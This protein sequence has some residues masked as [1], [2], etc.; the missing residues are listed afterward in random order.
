[1]LL[2]QIRQETDARAAQ[3]DAGGDADNHAL[4]VTEPAD[5]ADAQRRCRRPVTSRPASRPVGCCWWTSRS[6]SRRTTWWRSRRRALRNRRVGHA[7]TLDPFASGLLVLLVGRETRL[8][9]YV[10]GDPKVYEATVRFGAETATDDLTGAVIL[11][12][13]A[14]EWNADGVERLD[15]GDRSAHRA[16]SSSCPPAYSAKHVGGERAYEAARRG[17]ARGA[18]AARVRVDGWELRALRHGELD[19][20]SRAAAAPTSAPWRATSAGRSAARRT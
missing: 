9:P 16:S 10:A 20:P 1:M 6:A 4:D 8:L 2:G 19:V 11:E 5:A 12:A 15:R 17:E 7:G 13:P 18:A 14:P 3:A